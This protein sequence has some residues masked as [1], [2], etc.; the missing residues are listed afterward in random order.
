MMELQLL[1]VLNNPDRYS[2]YREQIS[3]MVL[4][5]EGKFI[6]KYM[7]EYFDAYSH[8]I[9]S[10]VDFGTWVFTT[11]VPGLSGTKKAIYSSLLERLET[12]GDTEEEKDIFESVVKRTYAVRIRE[13]ADTIVTD[14]TVDFDELVH[15]VKEGHEELS[16][17]SSPVAIVSNIFEFEEDTTHGG[18]VWRLNELNKTLGK[19]RPGD[20]LIFGGRPDSGKTTLLASEITHFG[21]Q[22]AG[23]IL[24]LTNEERASKMRRRIVQ[25]AIAKTN[26][27]MEADWDRVKWDYHS[28]MH[29]NIVCL[30]IH[31]YGI[32]ELDKLFKQYQPALVVFDQ[33]SKVHLGKGPKLNDAE[34]L[35]R[36]AQ[37]AREWSAEFPVITTCWAD[38]SSG[39]TQ[40]IE[41]EQLYGS[42]TGMQGEADAII[43]IGRSYDPKYKDARFLYAPKNKL[44]GGDPAERN[45][46]WQVTILPEIARFKGYV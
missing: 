18:L 42:K 27:E 25:A 44:I 30:D 20:F 9:S 16:K 21:E 12:L 38:A 23:A 36:I 4:T 35:H 15:E 5:E 41:M 28:I 14:P 43:T 22:T 11:R 39:G 46:R 45:G 40:F 19:L 3:D 1:K 26:K 31:G 33:L 32:A 2:R 13:K 7:G 10:W 17:I 34:R 24:V 8:P 6:L 37:K 29:A